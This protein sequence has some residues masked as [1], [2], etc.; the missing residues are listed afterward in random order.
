MLFFNDPSP[1]FRK[2]IPN[3]SEDMKSFVDSKIFIKGDNVKKLEHE[4]SNFLG[5]NEFIGCANGT[6]A[7][8][9]SLLASGIR[10]GSLIAIPAITAPATAVAVIRANMIPV[11]IDVD[12]MALMCFESLDK[13]L[14]END[15]KGIVFVHL[16]GNVCSLEKISSYKNEGLITIED[17]AQSF[18]SSMNSKITGS[19]ANFGTHSFYPTKNLSCPGDGGGISI[20][21]RNDDL[22]ER[23]RTISEYGWN[24]ERKVIDEGL[25]S[26]LDELHAK[27]L[28]TALE[29]FNQELS[30]KRNLLQNIFD[31]LSNKKT[32]KML[33]QL[34][35]DNINVSPHLAVMNCK[36][37]EEIEHL[38]KRHKIVLGRHYE[39]PLPDH[40]YFKNYTNVS[41]YETPNW[42]DISRNTRS[43]PFFWG[44]SDNENKQLMEFLDEIV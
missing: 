13:A 10:K 18:G 43:I 4:L 35:E 39:V 30:D 23:V 8:T 41:S 31:N 38:A 22:I 27:F 33:S 25:N 9:I 11:I 44:M 40:P 16:Y 34:I 37:P 24:N 12:E 2:L 3:I 29:N 36:D 14:L 42:L 7:I 21:D 5:V 1:K 15:I 28:L 6:D 19:V 20:F 32:V 26:R 17:C